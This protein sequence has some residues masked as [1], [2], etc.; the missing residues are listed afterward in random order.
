VRAPSSRELICVDLRG[1]KAALVEHARA[2]GV[3]PSEF[4]RAT[5]GEALTSGGWTAA[6][7]PDDL[8][9]APRARVRL[10]L[11]MSVEDRQ[12][13]LASARQA[14][15]TPGDYVAGLV[16]GVP[17]LTSGASRGE[18]LAALVA[19]NAA[20]ATLARNLGQLTSLSRQ[21][22]ARAAHENL[23]ITDNVALEVREHVQHVSAVLA[24]LRPGRASTTTPRSSGGQRV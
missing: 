22:S 20:M 16:A 9:Q 17:A 10:S 7:A 21:G 19:S 6:A 2:R 12:A 14:G 3:S 18:H 5:L 4:L 8:S 13:V 23:A 1:M 15:L 24:D 11:R